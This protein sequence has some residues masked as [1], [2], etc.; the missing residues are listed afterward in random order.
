MSVDRFEHR[1][2]EIAFFVRDLRPPD[3]EQENHARP[4]AG[5]VLHRVIEH[6]G[7]AFDKAP[8]SLP[9][10]KPQDSGP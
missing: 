5:F 10:G 6:P 4:I 7:V 9:T 3:V 1:A 2:Y 8:V